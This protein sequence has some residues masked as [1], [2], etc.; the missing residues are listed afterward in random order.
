MKL[1][2]KSIFGLTIAVGCSAASAAAV[3]I[4]NADFEDRSGTQY[5]DAANWN[6][7]ASFGGGHIRAE[8]NGGIFTT[9]ASGNANGTYLFMEQNE[10]TTSG[11]LTAVA[12]ST[13]YTATVQIGTPLASYAQQPVGYLLEILLDGSVVGSTETTALAAADSWTT[14]SATYLSGIGA[15]GQISLRLG[16][17]TTSSDQMFFDNVTLDAT[18][19]P[20]PSSSMLIGLGGL[21][22]ILRRRK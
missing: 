5:A 16:D 21:A 4:P 9:D 18:A 17:G 15:T 10:V 19:I 3:I 7:P 14:L 11:N 13:L 1:N 20:E 2:K 8:S 6:T 12:D 22:L